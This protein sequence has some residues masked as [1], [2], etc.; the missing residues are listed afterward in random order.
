MDSCPEDDKGGNGVCPKPVQ[1]SLEGFEHEL[2]SLL[3]RTEKIHA[4]L[5]ALLPGQHCNVLKANVL[6]FFAFGQLLQRE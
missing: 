2:N 6:A 3:D 5:M 4:I 1:V